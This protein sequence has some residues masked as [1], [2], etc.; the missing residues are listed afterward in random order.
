MSFQDAQKC[1]V[2]R[3]KD[4]SGNIIGLA[5]ATYWAEWNIRYMV[6]RDR[7]SPPESP[8]MCIGNPLSAASVSGE[9]SG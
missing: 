4:A 8:A 9:V 6:E 3:A 1:H 5:I 2:L 7:F